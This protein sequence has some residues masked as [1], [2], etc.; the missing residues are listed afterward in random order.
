[1]ESKTQVL[2]KTH[3]EIREHRYYANRMQMRCWPTIWVSLG[4]ALRKIL[5]ETTAQTKVLSQNFK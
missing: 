5:L 4:G 1:M 3:F 2:R